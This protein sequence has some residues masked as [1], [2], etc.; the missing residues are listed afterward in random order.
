MGHVNGN[1]N[2]A[3]AGKISLVHQPNE[4][5]IIIFLSIATGTIE[6]KIIKD[7]NAIDGCKPEKQNT[8]K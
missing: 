8:E 7:I 2:I 6:K 3:L 1:S 5:V 4:N